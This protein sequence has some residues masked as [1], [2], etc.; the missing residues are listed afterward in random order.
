MPQSA[1]AGRRWWLSISSMGDHAFEKGTVG[2]APALVDGGALPP[3]SAIRRAL[4]DRV[5]A[6]TTQLVNVAHL[7]PDVLTD[8]LGAVLPSRQQ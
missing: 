6:V 5:D 4:V 8:L 1:N 2:A 3:G 7:R